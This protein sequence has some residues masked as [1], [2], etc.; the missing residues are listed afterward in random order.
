MDDQPQIT[1]R[2]P[3]TEDFEEEPLRYV[4]VPMGTVDSGIDLL[5]CLLAQWKREE[6]CVPDEQ[7]WD[8]LMISAACMLSSLLRA[9]TA[10]LHQGGA[11]EL[12]EQIAWFCHWAETPERLAAV[13]DCPP[14]REWPHYP[15]GAHVV[16]YP[17][18]EQIIAALLALHEDGLRRRKERPRQR[19]AEQQPA[20]DDDP[21]WDF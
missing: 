7:V 15:A 11:R 16:D 10:Y 14:T 8:R 19:A 1:L 18:P 4:P 6:G 3:P 20:A 21:G 5:Q 13:R 17:E 9:Q 2:I 12:V